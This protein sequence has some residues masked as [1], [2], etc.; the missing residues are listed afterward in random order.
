M[1]KNYSQCSI[2]GICSINNAISSLHEIVLLHIKHLA[3]YLLKL[4]E[5]GITNDVIRSDLTEI[6][7]GIC[8][9]ICYSPTE[10]NEIISSIDKYIY[11]SVYLYEK[12]CRENNLE[13][14]RPT[15]RLKKSKNI[16]DAI[17]DGEKSFL[18]KYKSLSKEQQN[19]YEL[20]Y[21][22]CKSIIIKLVELNRLGIECKDAYYVVLSILNSCE[23]DGFCFDSVKDKFDEGLKVYYDLIKL[24][25]ATQKKLYGKIQEADID[26]SS[27]EGKAILV[28]GSDLKSLKTILEITEN[29]NINIYTHG[30][31]ML[32]AHTL[33][34]ISKHSHLRGHFSVNKNNYIADFSTFRG[35][36][37]M[38]RVYM[39]NVDFLYRGRLFSLDPYVSRGIS[40]IKDNDFEPLI[41]ATTLANG[42]KKY[43]KRAFIH[44]GFDEDKILN[45]TDGILEKLKNDEIKNL[46]VIGICNCEQNSPYYDALLE[47]IPEKS[48]VF[49]FSYDKSGENIYHINSYYDGRLFL[50]IFRNIKDYKDKNISVFMTHGDRYTVANLLLVKYLGFKHVFSDNFPQHIITPQTKAILEEK[51][52]INFVLDA[53]SDIEKSMC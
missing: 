11:Q 43:N 12:Y 14:Q 52:G 41:K 23:I 13:I 26:M 4:K 42:F 30:F 9:N 2:N 6:L 20:I 33:P 49:S 45:F 7:Y 36:I 17:K 3:F 40:R 15:K 28:S 48:Y 38:S 50:K 32:V 24:I 16:I 27:F 53:K 31:D 19:I 25:F 51:F 44:A 1:G 37:L 39:E 35:P 8:I 5:Y 34:E 21:L 29:S 46:Y 22:L 10:Y 18:N 47:N